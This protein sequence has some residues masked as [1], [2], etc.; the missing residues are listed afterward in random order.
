M[1]SFGQ[2][3]P[4]PTY[5]PM[6]GYAQPLKDRPTSVTAMAIIGIIW[7]ILNLL[8]VGYTLASTVLTMTSGRSL[9]GPPVKM[10]QWMMV[11]GIVACLISIGLCIMLLIGCIGSFYLRKW[12]RSVVITWSIVTLLY[13]TA[14]TVYQ[15]MIIPETMAA[16]RQSQPNNP[17]LNQSQAIVQWAT[18]GGII[19]GWIMHSIL[20]VL[21]LILWNKPA[22][23]EAFEVQVPA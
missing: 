2:T 13:I 20:P 6:I 16:I 9:F 14:S 4:P 8:C 5:D 18:V 1:T 10:P 11:I 12:A 22:V 23:K 7:A 17:A 3:P 19:F 21:F 15:L